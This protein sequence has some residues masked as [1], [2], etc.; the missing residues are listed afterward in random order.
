MQERISKERDPH[1][2]VKNT[3]SLQDNTLGEDSALSN[4][5]KS[6]PGTSIFDE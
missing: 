6:N 2:Q 1:I 3:M 4:N 5:L